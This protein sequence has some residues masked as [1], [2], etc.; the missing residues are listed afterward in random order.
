MTCEDIQMCYG[1]GCGLKADYILKNIYSKNG[2]IVYLCNKCTKYSYV[3]YIHEDRLQCDYD[4]DSDC[5][6]DDGIC[7]KN[8][9]YKGECALCRRSFNDD[10]SSYYINSI[11]LEVC[12]T[13]Y[14]NIRP[15]KR[16]VKVT[17]SDSPRDG[18]EYPLR[19]SIKI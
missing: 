7:S 15:L 1:R 2:Q 3:D 11:D 19:I 18:D 6:D 12:Q 5:E 13:C 10:G 8:E 14:E 9:E 17:G 4:C 16:K